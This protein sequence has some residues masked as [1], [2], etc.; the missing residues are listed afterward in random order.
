VR[1]RICSL[2]ATRVSVMNSSAAAT[3]PVMASEADE[4]ILPR[5]QFIVGNLG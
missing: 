5:G 1:V 3:R 2:M 4:T